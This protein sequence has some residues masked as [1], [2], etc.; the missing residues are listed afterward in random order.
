M[1][2]A[3]PRMT[4]RSI[5]ESRVDNRTD[6]RASLRFFVVKGRRRRKRKNFSFFESGEI[7]LRTGFGTKGEMHRSKATS[8]K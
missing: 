4:H 3:P 1:S 8:C 6:K 7:D 2:S 5:S